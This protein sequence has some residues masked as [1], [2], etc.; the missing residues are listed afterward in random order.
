MI[1]G[2]LRLC[3]LGLQ[4]EL[5]AALSQRQK[6][7][8]PS[9]LTVPKMSMVSSD[10]T[11]RFLFLGMLSICFLKFLVPCRYVTLR[12]IALDKVVSVGSREDEARV[13]QNICLLVF[14]IF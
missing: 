6:D 10:I 7:L 4:G 14:F 3:F 9:Y 2:A 11:S 8:C 13:I 1:L 12:I 5:S